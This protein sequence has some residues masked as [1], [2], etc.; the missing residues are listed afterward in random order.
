M[1]SSIGLSDSA[2]H[3]GNRQACRIPYSRDARGLPMPPLEGA[4]LSS[5]T[6]IPR[7]RISLHYICVRV[8]SLGH[9]QLFKFGQL[10]KRWEQFA[11]VSGI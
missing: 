1:S 5:Y 8:G 4:R 7:S 11:G 3:I 9:Y 10:K 2:R 6:W